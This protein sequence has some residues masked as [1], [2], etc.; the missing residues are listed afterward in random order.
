MNK[1]KKGGSGNKQSLI[2][3][4]GTLY[5]IAYLLKERCRYTL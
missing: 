4:N 5:T 1:L 3:L 2:K